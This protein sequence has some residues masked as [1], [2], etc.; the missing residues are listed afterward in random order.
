MELARP[1][2]NPDRLDR[3]GIDCNDDDVARGLTGKAMGPQ[4]GEGI[5]KR[6]GHPGQQSCRE[7]PHDKKMRSIVSHAPHSPTCAVFDYNGAPR[8]APS[9]RRRVNPGSGLMAAP[10]RV[11]VSV[12]GGVTDAVSDAITDAVCGTISD[13]VSV[14]VAISVV[15]DA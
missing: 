8:P 10:V 1:R 13:A 7:S 11:P 4:V 5:F 15:A 12:A 14:S 6:V 2:P 3:A 9:R